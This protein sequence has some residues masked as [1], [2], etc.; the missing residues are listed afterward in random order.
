VLEGPVDFSRDGHIFLE[1]FGRQATGHT[2]MGS[3][4]L[5]IVEAIA[6]NGFNG[7]VFV[8]QIFQLPSDYR[9]N[10]YY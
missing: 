9:K 1:Y 6:K 3:P 2:L 7:A 10:A 5:I 4:I 8:F